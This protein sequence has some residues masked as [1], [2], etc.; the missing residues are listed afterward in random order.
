MNLTP[1][2]M[3]AYDGGVYLSTE[4]GDLIVYHERGLSDEMR[5]ELKAAKPD[6][7]VLLAWNKETAFA[8]ISDVLAYAAERYVSGMDLSVLHEPGDRINEAF[9]REDM[10]G[11]RVAVRRYAEVVAGSMRQAA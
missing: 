4:D 10:H 8:L 1:L 2:L 5:Q 3:R 6:L 7:L 9:A 11:L